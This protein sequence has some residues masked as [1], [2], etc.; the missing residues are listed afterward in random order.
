[1]EGTAVAVLIYSLQVTG[2]KKPKIKK[3]NEKEN[4][5]IS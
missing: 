3:S 5:L 2:R 1:M 4:G